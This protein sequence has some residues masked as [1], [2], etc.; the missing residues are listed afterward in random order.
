MNTHTRSILVALLV[1]LL[2]SM[3][4]G[5][6]A[7]ADNPYPW[8]GGPP[9]GGGSPFPP[10][11]GPPPGGGSPSYPG[12]GYPYYNYQYGYGYP[13]YNNQPAYNYPYYNNQPAYN[14]PYYNN[15]P[16]YNYPYY[17]NQPNYNYGSGPNNAYVN[18]FGPVLV[19]WVTLSTGQM[20]VIPAPPYNLNMPW[21]T[22]GSYA[23][24]AA[25][26]QWEHGRAPGD[27]DLEQFWMSQAAA[28]V[29]RIQF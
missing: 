12:Y 25:Q 13:Y 2:L 29:L 3:A 5:S 7:L 24:W 6:A 23:Y 10:N 20:V 4:I 11:G 9:P 22:F 8:N 19:K 14:Y 15:Q 26:F 18:G 21:G 17:N 16:N 27:G 1:G 28:G